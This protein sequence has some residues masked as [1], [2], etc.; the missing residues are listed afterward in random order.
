LAVT[1]QSPGVDGSVEATPSS[2]PGDRIG[3][4]G[5]SKKTSSEKEKTATQGKGGLEKGK[6][7]SVSTKINRKRKN[8][9]IF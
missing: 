7:S 2:T 3:E 9:P 1:I 6:N 8:G 5:S 4:K